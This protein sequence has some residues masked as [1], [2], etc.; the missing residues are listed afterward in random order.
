MKEWRNESQPPS[1][2]NMAEICSALTSVQWVEALTYQAVW[3]DVITEMVETTEHHMRAYE[4]ES[5]DGA[6]HV[7]LGTASYAEHFRNADRAYVDSTYAA[8]PNVFGAYQLLTL[9]LNIG[10]EV[11][12]ASG[13]AYVFFNILQ[14]LYSSWDFSW[15][16]C[17]LWLGT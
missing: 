13:P 12:I 16:R 14:I 7:I 5:D 11:R 17:Y 3:A 10:S 9:M 15:H 8:A 4:A 6:V 1:P 2:N